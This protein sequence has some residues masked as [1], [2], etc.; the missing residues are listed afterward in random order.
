MS[1]QTDRA[2]KKSQERTFALIA[3][4]VVI[5]YVASFYWLD[6]WMVSAAK[7]GALSAIKE[8]ELVR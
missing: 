1:D 2:E 3:G 7:R 5:A 8:R 6:K 4:G